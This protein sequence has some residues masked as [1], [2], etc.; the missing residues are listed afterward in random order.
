[1]TSFVILIIF[2]LFI[3]ML[4]YTV[5]VVEETGERCPPLRRAPTPAG[6]FF[7]TDYAH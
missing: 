4:R 7:M 5:I 1:M 6:Y 3:A 2:L